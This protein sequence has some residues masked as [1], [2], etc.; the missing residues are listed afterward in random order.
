M[1][2]FKLVLLFTMGS[3]LLTACQS[4]SDTNSL[5]NQTKNSSSPNLQS[6][7]IELINAWVRPSAKGTNSAIYI[8]VYNGTD[9]PD[10]LMSVKTKI[11]SNSEI[12]EAFEENGLMGMRPAG[13]QPIPSYSVL[14]L[15]PGGLHIM[16]MRLTRPLAVGDSVRLQL[17]F[18]EVGNRNIKIPVKRAN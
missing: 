5:Q 11:A 12:H 8:D 15:Q 7:T 1:N 10:T 13:K 3:F 4:K 14:K 9:K 2:Y 17:K 16:L 6:N 18:Y